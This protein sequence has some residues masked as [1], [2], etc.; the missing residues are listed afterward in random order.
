MRREQLV[1]LVNG[2]PATGKTTIA[3]KFAK[4]L[5]VPFVGRDDIKEK[6]FDTLG[7]GNREWSRKMGKAS[8]DLMYYVVEKLLQTGQSFVVETVFESQFANQKWDELISQFGFKLIQVVCETD[9]EIRIK[10]FIDRNENGQ[11]HP[12]HV[13]HNNYQKQ[14]IDFDPINCSHQLLFV[15]TNNF[16]RVDINSIVEEFIT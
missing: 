11:R 2:K 8:F 10:R 12:G 1:V 9:D 13:D 5:G 16:E 15:N 3:K 4:R 7:V 6:L 14:K